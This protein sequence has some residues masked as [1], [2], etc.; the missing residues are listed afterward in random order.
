MGLE[1]LPI[2]TILIWT[3]LISKI[4]VGWKICDGNNN[5]PNLLGKYTKQVPTAATN[6]GGTGGSATHGHTTQAH[7]HGGWYHFHAESSAPSATATIGS[8]TKSY[9]TKSHSHISGYGT[10]ATGS[11]TQNVASSDSNPS[12]FEVAYIMRF[13]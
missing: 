7:D 8:G 6:P 5:T 11:S 3:G 2:G 1:S 12:Y 13:E 9:E 4:P 10:A